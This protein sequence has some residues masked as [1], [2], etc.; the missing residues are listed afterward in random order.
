MISLVCLLIKK[1]LHVT[2]SHHEILALLNSGNGI[3]I[4][5][6]AL[7]NVVNSQT[8]LA[9]DIQLKHHMKD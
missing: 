5:N 4:S 6:I 2:T 8:E 3:M 9:G 7:I 1:I